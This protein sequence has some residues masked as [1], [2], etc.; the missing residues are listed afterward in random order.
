[1]VKEVNDMNKESNFQMF[2]TYVNFH[3]VFLISYNTVYVDNK[4]SIQAT[5][6]PRRSN[7]T[8]MHINVTL[9]THP[10]IQ[11]TWIK[12][13]VGYEGNK[14]ANILSKEAV[15]A[16]NPYPSTEFPNSFLKSSFG[17]ITLDDWRT[18]VI[19]VYP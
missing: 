17:K 13:H 12:V 19:K 3:T 16:G 18:M 14:I 5:A 2:R 8:A 1:M 11:V 15:E 7:K 9:L 4:D 6:N 10:N